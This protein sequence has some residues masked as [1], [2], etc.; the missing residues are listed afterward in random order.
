MATGRL[1]SIRRSGPARLVGGLI[2]LVAAAELLSAWSPAVH[3]FVIST[4]INVVIV[5]GLFVFIGNS[6]VVSFGQISF[7]AL[8]AYATGL[9]TTLPSRKEFLL[10]NLPHFIASLHMATFPA[11]VLVAVGVAAVAAV[12]GIPL[13]RLSGLSASIATLSLLIVINVLITQSSSITG[14]NQTFIGVPLT[15][16]T[17]V[18]AAGACFAI[19]LVALFGRTRIGLRLRASRDDEP[20]ARA[21]GI[22]VTGERLVAFAISGGLVAMA[23]GLYAHYLGSFAPTNFYF[24]LTFITLAMLVVGGIFS[25]EGAVVGALLISVVQEVLGRLENGE[26]VGPIHIKLHDGVTDIVLACIVIAVMIFRPAGL[27]GGRAPEEGAEGGGG[28]ER[29]PEP[30]AE[31]EAPLELGEKPVVPPL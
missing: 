26:G 23:G 22:G 25:L 4:L 1:G 14:G 9:L 7:M 31:H 2:A 12:M 3:T 8:G 11:L 13:M 17:E 18:A 16:T 21:C 10:P 28:P 30:G 24:E 20:A 27:A 15:T 5:V 19:V 6:G 29:E